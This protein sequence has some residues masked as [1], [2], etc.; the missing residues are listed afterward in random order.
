VHN[1]AIILSENNLWKRL[2]LGYRIPTLGVSMEDRAMA[3]VRVNLSHINSGEFCDLVQRTGSYRTRMACVVAVPHMMAK[4][5]AGK[6]VHTN[7][8]AL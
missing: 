7:I 5:L 1:R 8:Q 6:E 3:G 2:M 4:K